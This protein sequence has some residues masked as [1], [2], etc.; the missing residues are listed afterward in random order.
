MSPFLGPMYVLLDPL[1]YKPSR[2]NHL[3]PNRA[4][5]IST[6]SRE[7]AP[8]SRE[9]QVWS[10]RRVESVEE[11]FVSLIRR[12]PCCAPGKSGFCKNRQLLLLSCICSPNTAE[13]QVQP[14]L[15]KDPTR[16]PKQFLKDE[17]TNEIGAK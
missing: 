17:M 8:W 3:S 16:K 9:L 11:R 1:A 14:F 15:G 13:E 4:Q 2:G 5:F 6:G 12:A 7:G 10:L